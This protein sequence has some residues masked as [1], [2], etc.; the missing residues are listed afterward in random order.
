MSFLY[1][2][3]EFVLPVPRFQFSCSFT[4]GDWVFVAGGMGT[5]FKAV[6]TF[7]KLN[8]ITGEA[9]NLEGLRRACLPYLIQK[10]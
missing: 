2:Q 5:D 10:F 1:F 8:V 7:V 6:D 9:V 3:L 4:D